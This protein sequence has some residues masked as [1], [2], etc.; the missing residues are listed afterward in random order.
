MSTDDIKKIF[1]YHA[2][3]PGSGQPA[4]YVLIREKALEFALLINSITPTSREQSIAL[5]HLQESVMMA[6]AAIALHSE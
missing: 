5:T 4:K 2:P 1:T 6:N 3:V